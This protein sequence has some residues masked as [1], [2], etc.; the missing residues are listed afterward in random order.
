M[1]STFKY[2]D[3]KDFLR[4]VLHDKDARR[5]SQANLAKSLQ[6][7]SSYIYQV[8]KGKGNLTDDQAY[9]VTE[10]FKMC[11][12]ERDY[13]LLL[14]RYSKATSTEL[15]K[16]LTGELKKLQNENLQLSNKSDAVKLDSENQ[17]WAYYF[18]STLPSLV[19]ILTSSNNY[20]TAEAIGKRLNI[21]PEEIKTCLNELSR[22]S[23]VIYKD[24]KWKHNSPSFHLP[25]ESPSNVSLQIM[26]RM[27]AVTSIL[28][29]SPTGSTHFSSL[30]TLDQDTFEKLRILVTD[31]IQKS[32][33]KI[34]QGGCDEMYVLCLDLFSPL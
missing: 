28:K 34:H 32:Q 26:R 21:S 17:A 29:N 19:H 13:F 18:S 27:Q 23:F 30:F 8:L 3:Y 20:Q 10:F 31:F 33:Q 5:G 9:G 11:A 22:H 24:R 4:N 2:M 12:L 14:V 1:H 25:K 15:K 7:Q 16:F 6:C